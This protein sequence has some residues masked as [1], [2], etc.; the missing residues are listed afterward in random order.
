MNILDRA[1]TEVI[2]QK[3]TD[4]EF[5]K[6]HSHEF[7]EIAF[8]QSGHGIHVLEDQTSQ[9]CA[10]CLYVIDVG[11][12]HMFTADSN[13]PFVIFNL[14]FRPAFFGIYSA[15]SKSLSDVIHHFLLRNFRY[16]DF[17][18][19]LSTRLEGE[20]GILISNLFERMYT[21]YSMKKP[22]YEELLRA[23]TLELMVYISRSMASQ[24]TPSVPSPVEQ[25]IFR[26]T[27]TYLQQN[28]AAP[29]S[30]ETLSK[31]AFMS[32]KYFSRLFKLHNGC[33]LTEYIQNL[34]IEHACEMLTNSRDSVAQIAENVGYSDVKYF[35]KLFTRLIGMSPTEYRRREN[36]NRQ[37][38]KL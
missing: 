4:F 37:I 6:M 8:V 16:G 13:T 27:F 2:V 29:V 34:R 9:C 33:T 12:S 14:I 28:Y 24:V 31:I 30:L 26:R 22:G 32:P 1:N 20:D 5:V 21:E 10:G 7:I 3:H 19:S 23:C 15:D 38:D 18:Q 17:S 25:D 36:H 35:K 11:D